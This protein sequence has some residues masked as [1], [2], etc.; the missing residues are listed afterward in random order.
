[1]NRMKIDCKL[2]PTGINKH[3]SILSNLSKKVPMISSLAST[4]GIDDP[5]TARPKRRI[6]IKTMEQIEQEAIDDPYLQDLY[7]EEVIKVKG[8][9]DRTYENDTTWNIADEKMLENYLPIMEENRNKEEQ[10]WK[11]KKIEA[12]KH[13]EQ[14]EIQEKETDDEQKKLDDMVTEGAYILAA[15]E[16]IHGLALMAG[17]PLNHALYNQLIFHGLNI[18]GVCKIPFGTK[19]CLTLRQSQKNRYLN[20]KPLESR[21]GLWDLQHVD[22]PGRYDR[23]FKELSNYLTRN[24]LS[25]EENFHQYWMLPNK[26]FEDPMVTLK[27]GMRGMYKQSDVMAVCQ[28]N[29]GHPTHPNLNGQY[30]MFYG[31]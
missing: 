20:V 16:K 31:V 22:N 15:I 12:K 28:F 17:K 5:T 1:M 3:D 14:M 29:V 25:N 10:L 7:Y 6:E 4:L 11:A 26:G 13:K 2:D 18:H 9:Q 19:N 8:I 21:N 23:Y 24:E 27:S 30:G